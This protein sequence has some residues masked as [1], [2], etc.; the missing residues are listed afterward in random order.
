M[1]RTTTKRSTS[2]NLQRRQ[3]LNP[4]KINQSLKKKRF[5]SDSAG[6][7]AALQ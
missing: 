6:I 3:G 7:Y 2:W 4:P 1:K 5:N